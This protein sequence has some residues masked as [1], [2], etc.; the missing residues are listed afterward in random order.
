MGMNIF[1]FFSSKAMNEFKS[2]NGG[3]EMNYEQVQKLA[4]K[5]N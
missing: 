1:S 4:Q 3:L 2:Q 5:N